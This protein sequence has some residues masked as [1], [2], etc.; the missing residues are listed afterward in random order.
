MLTAASGKATR[1][2]ILSQAWGILWA[3]AITFSHKQQLP[4]Y[5][6]EPGIQEYVL[7]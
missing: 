7:I 5:K 1:S 2:V 6:G 3:W 4:E